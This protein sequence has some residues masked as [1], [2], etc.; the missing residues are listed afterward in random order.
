MVLG[1]EAFGRSLGHEGGGLLSGAS[2]K[3]DP[4]EL[5]NPVC[6]VRTWLDGAMSQDVG[7][8]QTSLREPGS[9]TSSLQNCE[10]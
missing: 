6:P 7:P 10:R 2:Y 8:H 9:W 3:R 5:L 4:A 1:D